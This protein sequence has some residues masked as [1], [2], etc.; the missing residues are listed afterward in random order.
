MAKRIETPES[1]KTPLMWIAGVILAGIVLIS[2]GQAIGMWGFMGL[3]LAAIVI[4]T[5]YKASTKQEQE[6]RE[7]VVAPEAPMQVTITE[8]FAKPGSFNYNRLKCNLVIDVYLSKQDWQK[9]KQH[10]LLKRVLFNYPA[11]SGDDDT[12][13]F[14][15]GDLDQKVRI[16]FN[17]KMQMDEAKQELLGAL[18]G[19]R[20]YLE[21]D[22]GPKTETYEI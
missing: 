19:L 8:E 2:V 22:E 5:I 1:W 18:R 14:H 10:G 13:E 6:Q 7:S 9:I 4:Y 16:G 11:P 21:Q 17:D 3:F 15:V 12:R 20:Q